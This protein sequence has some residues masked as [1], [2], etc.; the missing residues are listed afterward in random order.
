MLGVV[1][2]GFIAG[3]F[4]TMIVGIFSLMFLLSKNL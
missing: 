2:L 3:L 4:T 1:F